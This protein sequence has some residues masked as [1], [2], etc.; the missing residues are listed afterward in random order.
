MSSLPRLRWGLYAPLAIAGLLF[1]GYSVAWMQTAAKVAADVEAWSADQ[2]G[3]G[4]DASYAAI[5]RAGF[6]FFLRIVLEEPRLAGAPAANGGPA[7]SWRADKLTLN[8]TPFNPNHVVASAKGEQRVTMAPG[9]LRGEDI[10]WAIEAEAARASLNRMGDA[11]QRLRVSFANGVAR[12]MDDGLI[13]GAL[14]FEELALHLETN[15]EGEAALGDGALIGA[16]GKNLQIAVGSDLVG[17]ASFD[18][19]SVTAA[20]FVTEARS[21]DLTRLASGAV[22]DWAEQ[23]GRIEV[24]HFEIADRS[25]GLSATGDLTVGPDGHLTGDLAASLRNPGGVADILA[26]RSGLPKDTVEGVRAALVLMALASGGESGAL[27]ADLAFADG[28]ARLGP[29]ELFEVPTLF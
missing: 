27:K 25:V 19:A 8:A 6:P 4:K 29:L 13:A 1:L 10:V 20:G 7:W 2:R 14:G 3:A 23:G 24:R 28:A 26:A 15:P 9:A 5:K 12:R 17:D 18:L 21:I 16:Q 22:A 11:E